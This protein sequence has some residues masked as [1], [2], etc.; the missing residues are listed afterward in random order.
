MKL[1]NN[2][3]V[4]LHDNVE[5]P[6]IDYEHLFVWNTYDSVNVLLSMSQTYTTEDTRQ[7]SVA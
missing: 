5:S 7:L 2:S 4:Y 6:G 3:N 1:V